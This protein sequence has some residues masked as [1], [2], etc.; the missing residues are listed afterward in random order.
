MI[1]LARSAFQNPDVQNSVRSVSSIGEWTTYLVAV[2]VLAKGLG[3]EKC[4][5]E[6]QRSH[7][8]IYFSHFQDIRVLSA[9]RTKYGD[10]LLEQTLTVCSGLDMVNIYNC[11]FVFP[12]KKVM[13]VSL[14]GK[15]NYG[16]STF[17][18]SSRRPSNKNSCVL[19]WCVFQAWLV[20]L[21]RLTNNVKM[22]NVC[23]KT[24]LEKH[25]KRL[26]MTTTVDGQVSVRAIAKT[27]AS[28]KTEKLVY[29]TLAECGLPNGKVRE[30]VWSSRKYLLCSPVTRNALWMNDRV[31]RTLGKS[32]C[33]SPDA[34]FAAFSYPNI[35][36]NI[37][38]EW[39]LMNFLHNRDYN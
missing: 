19:M 36:N 3:A 26:R 7:I 16:F 31:V 37:R 10:D 1:G 12:S 11:Y 6:P 5:R 22:N 39:P 24:N 13:E 8:H 14:I 35:S 2:E 28:G 23:P 27:F 15:T 21:R 29:Q 38:T 9:L 34:D 20:G 17:R 4:L 25:W 18:I 30:C 32:F 33:R